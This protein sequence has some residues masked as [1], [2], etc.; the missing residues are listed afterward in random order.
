MSTERRDGAEDFPV[1][2]FRVLLAALVRHFDVLAGEARD[3]QAFRQQ[4]ESAAD[5]NGFNA[6]LDELEARFMV[7]DSQLSQERER[8]E[9]SLGYLQRQCEDMHNTL[10]MVQDALL[11]GSVSLDNLQGELTEAWDASDARVQR[12]RRQNESIGGVN[13]ELGRVSDRLMV[14]ERKLNEL[15]SGIRNRSDLAFKD[16]STGLYRDDG[17]QLRAAELFARWQRAG[18]PL[19]AV[20]VSI[21][22]AGEQ[23]LS[24]LSRDEL[25]RQTATDLERRVRISDVVGVTG[26]DRFTLLLPDTNLEGCHAFASRMVLALET[27]GFNQLDKQLRVEVVAG[28]T[29]SVE[30]DSLESLLGRAAQ[31][32]EEA[33]SKGACC[34]ALI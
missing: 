28:I 15:R 9:K 23:P 11:Q 32:R 30:G 10:S 34:E 13:E 24:P 7:A 16:D 14:V 2:R 8:E 19:S 25:M 20:V 3:T 1:E 17:F 26:E 31:A 22:A 29:S 6:L 18:S 27:A 33:I 4:L 21:N 5:A 12:V